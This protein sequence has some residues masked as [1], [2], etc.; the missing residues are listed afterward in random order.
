MT[1]ILI[2]VS[3]GIV[4]TVWCSEPQHT[5]V[6]VRDMDAINGRS[7]PDPLEEEPGLKE[8]RVPQFV[9]Y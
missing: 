6:Y 9:V 5:E 4:Q 3:G 2:E 1:R 7:D 8:L